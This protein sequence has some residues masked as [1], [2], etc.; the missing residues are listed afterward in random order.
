MSQKTSV[1]EKAKLILSLNEAY[2][3]GEGISNLTNGAM[4][5]LYSVVRP[6]ATCIA[7]CHDGSRKNFAALVKALPTSKKYKG[8]AIVYPKS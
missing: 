3:D 1:E 5:V 6:V 2:K 8:A 4:K 7:I